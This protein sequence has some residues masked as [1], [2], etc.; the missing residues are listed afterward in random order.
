ML[1]RPGDQCELPSGTMPFSSRKVA[2]FPY[3]VPSARR[4]KASRIALAAGS[5]GTRRFFSSRR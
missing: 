5:S 1:M 4:R 2:I 3:E